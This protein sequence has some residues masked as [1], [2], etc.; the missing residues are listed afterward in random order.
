MTG[1][2]GIHVC[3]A[4]GNDN[5]RTIL[6]LALELLNERLCYLPQ[7]DAS[8]VSPAR[9]TSANTVGA[10]NIADRRWASSNFSAVLNIFALG[11]NINMA[12]IGDKNATTWASGT[13]FACPHVRP[14]TAVLVKCKLTV[15]L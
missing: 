3:A 14:P 6:A 13:S 5:V 9:A 2:Y 7:V 4:A 8:T 10:S 15:Y 12:T 11:E 1:Q